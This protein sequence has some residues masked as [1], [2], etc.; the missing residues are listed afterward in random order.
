MQKFIL[1]LTLLALLTLTTSFKSSQIA[2][3]SNN[4]SVLLNSVKIVNDTKQDIRIHTGQAH[5]M[6]YHGG[7]STSV[8]CEVGRKISKSDGSKKGS[9]IFTINSDMCGKTVKLSAYL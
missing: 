6:L 4:D 8:S 7:G 2:A 9:L 5:V 3:L 1:S